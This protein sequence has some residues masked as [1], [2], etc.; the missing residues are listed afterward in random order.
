MF[1]PFMKS[2][3]NRIQQVLLNLQSNALKFTQNGSIKM[4][5]EITNQLFGTDQFDNIE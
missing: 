4:E 2:D 3:V 1:S 5:V